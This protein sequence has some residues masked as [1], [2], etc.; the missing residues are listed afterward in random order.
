MRIVVQRVSR[1][2]L[3]VGDRVVSSISKGVVA[4]CG[5]CDGDSEIDLPWMAK[6]LLSLRLWPD[7]EG[8]P[9]KESLQ[10]QKYDILLVSQFTLY[11]EVN[12]GTKPDFHKAMGGEQAQQL[13]QKFLQ[14]VTEQ[15]SGGKVC[16]GEFGAMMQVELVNDGPVTITINSPDL[17]EAAKTRLRNQLAA[18]EQQKKAASLKKPISDNQ[19]PPKA[20]QDER[21]A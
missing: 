17:D 19:T 6:K 7:A 15:H 13:Y 1:A 10:S 8:R 11:A 21:A 4:L 9:W 3:T 5:L 18:K 2:K 14:M 16:D 20:A 12:K